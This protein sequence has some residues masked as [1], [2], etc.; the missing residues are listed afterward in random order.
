MSSQRMLVDAAEAGSRLDLFLARRALHHSSLRGLSRSEIQRLIFEGQVTLNSNRAKSSARVKTNDVVE[1]QTLPPRKTAIEAEELPLRILFE[2]DDCIVINKAPGII[3]HP[4]GGQRNGT[5]VNA[6]LHHCP[7]IEGIGGER[8]PGIVHRLDKDT[9]GAMIVAKNAAAFQELARQFK[10]RSVI[11]EYLA[12][13]WGRVEPETGVIDRPIGR[14]RSDRKKMSSVRAL[15]RR[16]EAVTTWRAEKYFSIPGSTPA[17]S[18]LTL[19]RL[20]PR[21]GR[22]HQIRVHLADLGFPVVGDK[23]YGHKRKKSSMR[24]TTGSRVDLFPRQVLHAERL[25]INHPRSGQP[26]NFYAP[27]PDDIQ[28]LLRE[29]GNEST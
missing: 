29:L 14:H 25:A 15:S 17:Y 11:K 3:V 12:L 9:S 5:L 16:R 2:D 26:M 28:N 27:L 6:L 4:A 24:H 13:V 8:R 23:V 7:M 10:D 1:L 19:L 20:R 18:T 21:T 22:T